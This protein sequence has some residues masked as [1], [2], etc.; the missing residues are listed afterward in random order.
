MHAL[1]WSPPGL[2]RFRH[3]VLAVLST[4]H[5]FSIWECDGRVNIS[6]N[7]K[8]KVII[9]HAL[10]SHYA[11]VEKATG[12]TE[13]QFSKRKRVSRRVRAFAWS[14]AAGEPSRDGRHATTAH[15]LAVS[16]KAGDVV[17][18]RIR[19]PYDLLAVD[20]T[21]W[22]VEVMR[23][24]KLSELVAEAEPEISKKTKDDSF[25]KADHTI[26]NH[27][28]RGP[29]QTAEDMPFYAT[30]AFNARRKLFT[31]QIQTESDQASL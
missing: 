2:G 5:V 21:E 23:S 14:P 26:A 12:E 3:C 27:I 8:R 9:N 6:A 28:A 25:Q 7:W 19:S 31:F 4:N 30:L 13:Q 29:W 22:Q 24:F 20:S 10:I 16:T 17:T 18:L 15:L 11:N 1:E